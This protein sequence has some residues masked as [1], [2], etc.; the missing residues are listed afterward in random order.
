MTP[1]IQNIYRR[2]ENKTEPE[3]AL[4]FLLVAT[5]TKTSSNQQHILTD[6]VN[7]SRTIEAD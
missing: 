1:I 7:T 2:I 5:S 6:R 4:T 3:C